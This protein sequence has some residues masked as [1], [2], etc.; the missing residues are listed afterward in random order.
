MTATLPKTITGTIHLARVSF[1]LDLTCSSAK[2][3]MLGTVADIVLGPNRMNVFT[4]V[5]ELGQ[6][7][8]ESLGA[9]VKEALKDPV[10]FLESKLNQAWDEGKDLPALVS[11]YSE[12]LRFTTIATW[13]DDFPEVDADNF[14]E[15][16]S[17]K[18]CRVCFDAFSR[19]LPKVSNQ[20]KYRM[21]VQG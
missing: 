2:E 14:V 4:V 6:Q 3:I 13:Q 5:T 15:S 11:D 9:L 7:E 20:T 8:F 12:S 21:Q 16:V 17:G 19:A 10:R 18:M 1:T